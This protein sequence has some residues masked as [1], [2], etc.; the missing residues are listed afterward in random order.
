MP[1][2]EGRALTRALTLRLQEADGLVLI[3]IDHGTVTHAG[4]GD[5]AVPGLPLLAART[6]VQ[7]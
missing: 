1:V 2:R 3:N 4:D 7:R 5:L 6:F